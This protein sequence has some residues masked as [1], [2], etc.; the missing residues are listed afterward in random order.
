MPH[1]LPSPWKEFLQE[2][3]DRLTQPVAL[4]CIGGFAVVAYGLP[5]STNDLDY[6]K[7]LSNQVDAEIQG[8]GGEGTP[9]ARKYKV[10]LQ[11]VAIA[12]VPD[13]YEDRLT[14][15]FPERFKKLRLFILDP[16]DLVLSKLTRNEEHDRQDVAY[17]AKTQKLDPLILRERYE[18][19]LTVTLI[20][21]Q[22]QHD[23]TLEFWVE[24]YFESQQ[25]T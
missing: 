20:G 16:Y 18:Q 1:D 25:E 15:L 19:E 6:F 21:P 3:D 24:A 11:H 9:L 5:R 7:I 14:E 17:L 2:L 23:L 4:H 10:H 12:S 13:G 8:I 22:A